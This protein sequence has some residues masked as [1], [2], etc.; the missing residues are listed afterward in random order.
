MLLTAG[1]AVGVI[2]AV[3]ADL[4]AL[5]VTLSMI[6]TPLLLLADERFMPK[7]AAAVSSPSG[8]IASKS[9]RQCRSAGI[10]A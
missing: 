3:A 9:P 10:R 5:V 2:N 4:G 6:A 7:P 8:R 1:A